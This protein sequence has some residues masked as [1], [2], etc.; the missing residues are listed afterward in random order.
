MRRPW[1]VHI[2]DALDIPSESA[3][4]PKISLLGYSRLHI[5]GRNE[6]LAFHTERIDVRLPDGEAHIHG[7]SLV[8]RQYDAEGLTLEGDITSVEV[9]R[10]GEGV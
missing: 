7:H 3:Y 6:L 4:T 2:L 10:R 9:I 5:E 8:V 1:F